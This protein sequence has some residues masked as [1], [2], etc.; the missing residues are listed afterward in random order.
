MPVK[1]P[2]LSASMAISSVLLLAACEQKNFETLP[3]I[4]VDQLEVLGVQTPIK[5]V[6][7]RDR[8][9]EGLLVLSRVDGQA[10]DPDT[11]QEVDKVQLKATLYGRAAERDAFKPRWQIEQETSCPGLDLDVD[12]YTDVSDVS[13]LNKDGVAEVTV[14]S[15]AFCGGGIDPHDI[16]IELREGQASYT[17]TGQSLITPAGEEPIGG[18]RDDSASLKNAPQVLREHM[19]AVW[20]QVY[21]RPWSE[22]SP[23]VDDDPED[24]TE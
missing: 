7:F 8:D 16:S 19:D 18:E 5:S 10:T 22:T 9:G 4:P 20:Q 15:H 12:F 21:K 2:W 23:P 24:D 13:D 17:I 1:H 11:E 3:A 6:H 14:A